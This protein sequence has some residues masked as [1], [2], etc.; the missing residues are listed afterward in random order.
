MELIG[1]RTAPDLHVPVKVG[2]QDDESA[3]HVELESVDVANVE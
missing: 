2:L 3:S 1:P